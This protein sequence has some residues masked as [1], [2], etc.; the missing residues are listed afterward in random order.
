MEREG[1]SLEALTRRLIETPAEFLA[2]PRI[3]KRGMV[4]VAAVVWDLLRDLG[5]DPAEADLV[6]YRPTGSKMHEHR[7]RLRLV[8][9]ACWL[10][11]DG[12]FRGKA[13][14][15]PAARTL[16]DRTV[17]ELDEYLDVDR[18]LNDPDRREELVRRSLAGLGLRPAGETVAQASDRLQTLDS[19]ERERVLSEAAEAERRA[20]EI[21]EAMAKAAAQETANR[22]GE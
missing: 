11:H 3:G 10:L 8:L 13:E 22:Y 4:D 12:W 18:L 17:A 14:L 6:R 9:V 21:R 16:L 2:E 19:A 1:P 7:N 15:V 5:G 20:Q